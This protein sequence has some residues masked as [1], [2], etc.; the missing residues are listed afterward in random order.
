MSIIWEFCG[1]KHSSTTDGWNEKYTKCYEVSFS[2]ISFEARF[3]QPISDSH[4]RY[5]LGLG[6]DMTKIYDT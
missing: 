4:V 3:T 5:L 2:L 1:M 6:Y